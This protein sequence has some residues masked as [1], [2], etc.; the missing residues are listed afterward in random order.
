M[1]KGDGL[2]STWNELGSPTVPGIYRTPS[3]YE[4]KVKISQQDIDAARLAGNNS[5]VAL[6]NVAESSEPE[7]L[8]V[9]QYIGVPDIPANKCS[10]VWVFQSGAKKIVSGVFST[11]RKGHNWIKQHSLSGRLAA[12]PLDMG[13]YD[14]M[15]ENGWLSKNTPRV[16]EEFTTASQRDYWYEN[17]NCLNWSDYDSAEDEEP[18]EV[19]HPAHKTIE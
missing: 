12:Y 6:I 3:I 13:V 10:Y 17:G 2:S 5:Y 4:D 18:E 16:R 1:K 19:Y 8:W 15:E 11:H 7:N 9:I 14:W